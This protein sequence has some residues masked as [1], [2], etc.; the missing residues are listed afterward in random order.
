MINIII[1]LF[2]SSLALTSNHHWDLFEA[3]DGLFTARPVPPLGQ[4]QHLQIEVD[5]HDGE[6]RSDGGCGGDDDC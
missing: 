4:N 6:G 2:R 3:F 5:Q 1:L